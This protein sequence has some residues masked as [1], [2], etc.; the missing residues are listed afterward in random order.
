MLIGLNQNVEVEGLTYHV[1]TEDVE[2]RQELVSQVFRS[3]QVLH[4]IRTPY[5]D[6]DMGKD[7]DRHLMH[8]AQRQHALLVAATERGRLTP[9]T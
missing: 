9:K 8:K 4:T 7:P 3:G 1:Q 2:D 5:K 6:W